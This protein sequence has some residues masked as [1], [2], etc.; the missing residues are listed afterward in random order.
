M[1]YDMLANIS[2]GAL[3]RSRLP[4]LLIACNNYT[5]LLQVRRK[6]LNEDVRMIVSHTYIIYQRYEQSTAR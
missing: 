1:K 6:I 5:Q 2:Y 4:L 3:A